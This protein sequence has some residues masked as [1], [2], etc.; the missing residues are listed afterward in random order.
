MCKFSVGLANNIHRSISGRE[1]L[2]STREVIAALERRRGFVDAP[3]PAFWRK[4]VGDFSAPE[5]H[6]QAAA[7][8]L[9]EGDLDGAMGL[10]V[11]WASLLEGSA[12]E[13]SG[14]D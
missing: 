9:D 11:H 7:A 3:P 5:S 10:L 4:E 12:V 8:L 1:I 14:A 13:R 2:D 6:A